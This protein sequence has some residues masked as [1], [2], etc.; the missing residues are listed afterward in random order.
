MQLN[1][2]SYRMKDQSTDET[3]FGFLAQELQQV[4]PDAVKKF[5]KDG[6]LGI[7]YTY[8]IPLTVAAIQEQQK[9]IEKQQHEIDELTKLVEKILK[10]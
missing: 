10:Q 3:T 2:V 4:F 5:E 7:S 6:K 9:I 8:L 1:P